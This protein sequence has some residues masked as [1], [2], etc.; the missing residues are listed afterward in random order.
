MSD[1]KS[2]QLDFLHGS[3]WDK[4]IFFALPLILTSILQQLFNTADVAVVGKIVGEKALA[5][6]GCTGPV[7]NLFI[8]IFTG[9]AVGANAMISRLIGAG[10]RENA[11][12]AVHNAMAIALLSGLLITLVGQLIAKP[13]LRLVST[14]ED[15]LDLAVLYLRI[16]FGGS[17][18]LML[19]NFEAAILRAGG[20][21]KRP[22][23]ILLMAGI[24]NILL[25]LFFVLICGM[26]VE[27]VAIATLIS[28]VFSALLLLVILLRE[29][30][31]LQVQPAK[32]RLEKDMVLPILRVGIPAAVQGMLFNIANIVIQWGINGL[33]SSVVAGSTIGLNVEIFA[34][35]IVTGFGQA[36]VTFNSQNLGAG[37]L[38]RCIRATRWCMLLGFLFTLVF[39]GLMVLLRLPLA[40]LFT[41]EQAVAEIAAL[42]ILILAGLEVIN[43][44]IEVLSG[45][46]RGLGYSFTPTL[47]SAVFICGVRVAWL[48]WVFP[49]ERSFRWLLMAY[50]VS[51]SL[52]ALSITIAY[53]VIKRKFRLALT[54]AAE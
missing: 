53:F 47:L 48:W 10:D 9:L 20:D 31:I 14:P 40:S 7:V 22:L 43:L 25:N 15:V 6:V 44:V 51:W 34:Y 50:P 24:L 39:S 16:Y 46:L 17:I 35:Y 41:N 11:G 5:A 37:Q 23:Y 32:L 33:G 28:N 8:T 21:T 30:G 38:R 42:R 29:P 12:R 49:L 1:L 45:A 27:G 3:I 13:L 36:S 19:Y 18:F 2:R 52:A 54:A 26:S 4:V